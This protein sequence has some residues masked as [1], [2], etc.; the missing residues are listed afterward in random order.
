MLVIIDN[1]DSFTYNL[2]QYFGELK[3][4]IKVFRNDQVTIEQL[5]ELQPDY[6]VISPGPCTPKESGISPEAVR[7]FSGKV[8]VL[9][10]CLGHQC[11]GE[12]FGGN[13]IRAPYPVHG[14]LS[15]IHHNGQGLFQGIPEPFEAVRYHS[16]VVEEQTFPEV[17]EVTATTED[18]LIMGLKHRQHP[19]YGLQFHPESIFTGVGKSLLANFLKAG[20]RN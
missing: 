6:V 15:T 9:G 11:I 17:L 18:G 16:L 2:V 10:V 8:P 7:Y 4:D 19:T 14:K 3:V 20:N 13:V 5:Q 12:V 1:Y